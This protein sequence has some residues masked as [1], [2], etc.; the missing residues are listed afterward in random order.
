MFKQHMLSI[1]CQRIHLFAWYEAWKI[2]RFE[3]QQEHLVQNTDA[4][5]QR[6]VDLAMKSKVKYKEQMCE[7]FLQMRLDGRMRR[8]FIGWLM[9]GELRRVQA[10]AMFQSAADTLALDH[11]KKQA[12]QCIDGLGTFCIRLS[13]IISEQTAFDAWRDA[14]K[15][16]EVRKKIFFIERKSLNEMKEIR[17]ETSDEINQF[18]QK[19]MNDMYAVEESAWMHKVVWLWR[20]Q[21]EMR[22]A[23]IDLW[24][25][26]RA[27]QTDANNRMKLAERVYL[28]E[29]RENIQ[30]LGEWIGTWNTI[31]TLSALF[32]SWVYYLLLTT[33]ENEMDRFQELTQGARDWCQ[34]QIELS[35]EKTRR[36][37]IVATDLASKVMAYWEGR[38]LSLAAISF[39]HSTCSISKKRHLTTLKET[40]QQIEFEYN[41]RKKSA[42]S[43]TALWFENI[44]QRLYNFPRPVLHMNLLAYTLLAWSRN[45]RVAKEVEQRRFELHEAEMLYDKLLVETQMEQ[46][47][48]LETA[49]TYVVEQYQKRADRREAVACFLA[50]LNSTRL[51]AFERRQVAQMNR[52]VEIA[53]TGAVQSYIALQPRVLEFAVHVAV[54]T[55]AKATDCIEDWMTAHFRKLFTRRVRSAIWMWRH[56]GK[57]DA[58]EKENT[59]RGRRQAAALASRYEMM[60]TADTKRHRTLAEQTLAITEVR[61]Q[62]GHAAE[63]FT[64]PIFSKAQSRYEKANVTTTFLIWYCL[65]RLAEIQK[66]E[67][68]LEAIRKRPGRAHQLNTKTGRDEKRHFLKN[69]HNIIPVVNIYSFWIYNARLA[70]LTAHCYT[71]WRIFASRSAT[72]KRHNK[73]SEAAD[74]AAGRR[75]KELEA[76]AKAIE[77][78]RISSTA[79]LLFREG[80]RMLGSQL[81][82][83]WYIVLMNKKHDSE[84][85]ALDKK[86]QKKLIDLRVERTAARDKRAKEQIVSSY[87]EKQSRKKLLQLT[88]WWRVVTIETLHHAEMETFRHHPTTVA[89]KESKAVQTTGPVSV[90]ESYLQSH[91]ALSR[92]SPSL[93]D[94]RRGQA[95]DRPA[96][97]P[98]RDGNTNTPDR[99]GAGS[100]RNSGMQNYS[101]RMAAAAML[102]TTLHTAWRRRTMAAMIALIPRRPSLRMSSAVLAAGTQEFSRSRRRSSL[103]D[104]AGSAA[105][106]R[107]SL[108][109]RAAQQDVSMTLQRL[110]QLRRDMG[111]TVTDVPLAVAPRSR[112]P[113]RRD[114]GAGAGSQQQRQRG[115]ADRDKQLADV[116][117]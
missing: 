94:A 98:S 71:T 40:R 1:R 35:R 69:S 2:S 24:S 109:G 63:S 32:K 67:D 76:Y 112:T 100:R 80:Q 17:L 91:G 78:R 77:S 66:L 28:A 82:A 38:G 90:Q 72:G 42:C 52:Y 95:A 41:T 10:A 7:M 25:S 14:T 33:Y 15:E 53:K 36:Q 96:R 8:V 73:Q 20:Q 68:D 27:I 51:A 115:S 3:R 113:D 57:I 23:R 104:A 55:K 62:L 89:Y 6:M 101:N 102:G 54:A 43:R 60:E 50:W 107:P 106:G 81:M 97:R 30:N 22:D 9:C 88:I 21:L 59:D 79:Y 26:A 117:I 83:E 84:V 56:L 116:L 61:A 58:L 49:S 85:K 44:A 48:K 5:R 65:V 111:E 31:A 86:W 70:I 108:D 34:H 11:Y 87:K 39:W 75:T 64:L 110:A 99:R 105:R 93:G 37:M 47:R 46:A 4:Q 12:E 19:M 74:D 45:T 13:K 103:G 92:E 16:E 114:S 29:Q 18:R